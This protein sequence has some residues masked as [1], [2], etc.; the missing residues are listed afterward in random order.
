MFF[1][2]LV[3]VFPPSRVTCTFPSSVPTQ[4][5]SESSGD[6]AIAMIVQWNSAAVLSFEMSP[7]EDCCFDLSFVVRSGLIAVH[8]LPRSVE[9]NS[10]FPPKYTVPGSFAE[11]TIG[12]FQLKRYL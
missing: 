6:G 4:M 12:E 7:P 10:T 2:T 8:V 3:H 1:T 9:R 5:T 11:S